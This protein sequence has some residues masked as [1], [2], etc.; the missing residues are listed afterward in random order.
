A[1]GIALI[2]LGTIAMGASVATTFVTVV[3]YGVLLILGGIAECVGSF[4]ARQWSGFFLGLM[5]GGLYLVVGL[6]FVREPGNAAVAMT[7]LL[8]AL[9]LIGGAFRIGAAISFRMPGWG[10]AVVHG[11]VDVL[12]GM[13]IWAQWPLSGLWVIGLFVGIELV[14]AGAWWVSLALSLKA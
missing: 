12:L 3:I 2:I 1:L 11:A 14:F 9:L 5:A 6:L 13:L 8:A 10:W 7:L 4:W